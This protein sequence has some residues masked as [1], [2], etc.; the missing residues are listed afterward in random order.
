VF[1][2]TG[3]ITPGQLHKESFPPKRSIRRK[4]EVTKG[5]GE[6]LRNKLRG[7]FFASRSSI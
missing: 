5:R 2:I 1:L 6:Q 7:V 4:L 3:K